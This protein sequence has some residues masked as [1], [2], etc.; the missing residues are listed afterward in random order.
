MQRR[1][2]AVV[3]QRVLNGATVRLAPFEKSV[4]HCIL[5]FGDRSEDAVGEAGQECP[6]RL[7]QT[8]VTRLGHLS[9]RKP[10]CGSIG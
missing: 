1:V 9:A 5:G 4:L 8:Y 7:E 3:S 10:E 2:Q 6:P